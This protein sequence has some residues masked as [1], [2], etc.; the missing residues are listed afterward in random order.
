M[1]RLAFI[2][3][4]FAL[5]VGIFSGCKPIPSSTCGAWIPHERCDREREI[6]RNFVANSCS[7]GVLTEKAALHIEK[8]VPT[9]LSKARLTCK[10]AGSGMES[11]NVLYRV[12]A[13][14][15]CELIEQGLFEQG[16]AAYLFNVTFGWATSIDELIGKT[17]EDLRF[18]CNE[19]MSG[20]RL[21][22]DMLYEEAR[23]I[24]SLDDEV[25]KTWWK[26]IWASLKWPVTVLLGLLGV[27]ATVVGII[28]K[29]K[30]IMEQ[31]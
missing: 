10:L 22:R 16:Q 17:E 2:A 24:R 9:Q 21:G 31:K 19:F 12:L 1:K 14:E 28:A 20:R 6:A 29:L 4:C 3:V 11:D 15:K 26:D 18:N 8:N 7:E 13:G 25:I 23:I 5:F 30:S 27:V